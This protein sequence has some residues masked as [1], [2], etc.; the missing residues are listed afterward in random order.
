MGL[1]VGP[2]RH[3]TDRR[4]PVLDQQR[5]SRSDDSRE[6]SATLF[7][8]QAEAKAV[9]LECQLAADLP[10]VAAD[11][12]RVLQ[13]LLNLIGNALKFVPAG[14]AITLGAEPDGDAI[15][16]WVADTGIGIA[17]DHL[18]KVF[19]R[20]W[21]ADRREGGGVGLGLAVAKAIVEAHGGRIGVTS[22]LGG[23]S[24]FHFTLHVHSE[25]ADRWRVAGDRVVVADG[26]APQAETGWPRPRSEVGAVNVLWDIRR[27]RARARVAKPTAKGRFSATL[28]HELRNPLAAL[29][30]VWRSS[31]WQAV[32]QTR[33]WNSARSWSASC[34]SWLGWSTTCWTRPT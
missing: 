22:R 24:T 5:Q 18:T 23:G 17:D 14:S 33:S 29:R 8:P 6:G 7:Q 13:V 2:A 31:E 25:A 26:R 20:F 21:R 4:G 12:H 11:R 28:A 15:R 9:R 10:P 1:L 19:E 34:S 32:T 3:I 16:V 27:K 30:A